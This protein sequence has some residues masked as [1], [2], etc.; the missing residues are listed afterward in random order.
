[1]VALLGFFGYR[2]RPRSRIDAILY[3]SGDD[4]V[5]LTL[6]W[7]VIC[8]ASFGL[9]TLFGAAPGALI[10]ISALASVVIGGLI[11]AL[12]AFDRLVDFLARLE[13]Y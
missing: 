7:L 13:R 4:W 9:G 10:V 12:W 11:L 2:L 8:T 5:G 1:M 3:G 6:G